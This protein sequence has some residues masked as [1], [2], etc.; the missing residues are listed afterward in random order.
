MGGVTILCPRTGQQVQTGVRMTR[1]EFDAMPM[2]QATM[3]CWACGGEHSWSK[4][5]AT[6]V[7]DRDPVPEVEVPIA[8]SRRG[9]E[10]FRAR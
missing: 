2:I 9:R 3:H 6:Y 8:P 10:Q 7:D 4:R 1:Y 5:W